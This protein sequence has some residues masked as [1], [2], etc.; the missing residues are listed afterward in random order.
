MRFNSKSVLLNDGVN[1]KVIVGIPEILE[2]LEFSDKIWTDAIL[3]F[4]RRL[5]ERQSVTEQVNG[6]PVDIL[7]LEY[8][9]SL[10]MVSIGVKRT[11]IEAFE[12]VWFKLRGQILFKPNECPEIESIDITNLTYKN[13]S[14]EV[15][16]VLLNKS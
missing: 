6:L 8:G 4:N 11:D 2:K 15:C 5:N 10:I 13:A 9:S 1:L 14:G 12:D 7:N 3:N 16:E